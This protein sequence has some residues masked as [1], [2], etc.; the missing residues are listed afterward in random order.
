MKS[1]VVTSSDAYSTVRAR[2]ERPASR[3]CPRIELLQVL[4]LFNG[5]AVASVGF[6]AAKSQIQA[7]KFDLGFCIAWQ[8]LCPLAASIAQWQSTG[9]VNQGS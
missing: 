9:L 2:F 6:K 8:G 5:F 1:D 7:A 4:R 3:I